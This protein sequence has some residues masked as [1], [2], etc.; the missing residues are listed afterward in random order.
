MHADIGRLMAET[1]KLNAKAGKLQRERSLH[2]A[3]IFASLLGALGATRCGLD[4]LAQAARLTCK[5]LLLWGF[6][7][8]AYEKDHAL[9]T[10]ERG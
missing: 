1:V 6:L 7:I 3:V 4:R 2:P 5:A 9:R 8:G 10:A